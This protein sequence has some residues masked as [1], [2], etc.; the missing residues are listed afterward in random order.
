MNLSV[1]NKLIL[2][3][4]FSISGLLILLIFLKFSFNSIENLAKAQKTVETLSSDMLMLRRNEKD[5]IMRKDLKYKDKFSKNQKKLHANLYELEKLL[6]ASGVDSSDIKKFDT[7]ISQYKNIFFQ[8]IKKQQEIGLHHKDGLYG[9]L[10]ASVHKV[11]NSAK[12]SKNNKLLAIIYDLRKQEKD[13][14]LRRDMKYVDK[15]IK[16]HSSLLQ[17]DSLIKGDRKN[18]LILYKKDFLALIKAEQEIGLNSKV[19][20]QGKMR[21]VI[22]KSETLLKKLHKDLTIAIDSKK[23]KI[24]FQSIIMFIFIAG[25]II[26]SSAYIIRNISKSLSEFQSG[27]LGFFKYLNKQSDS[28]DMLKDKANDE[29]GNMAKIINENIIKTKKTIQNDDEFI[30]EVTLMVEDVNKGHL[31]KRFENKVESESLEKLRLSFNHMLEN[32]NNIIGGSTNKIIN[33]LESYEKLDFTNSIKDTKNKIPSTL[34][35]VSN[36]ITEMLIENKSTGLTLQQ[37]SQILIKNVNLL[38]TNSNKAATALEET[39]A[40][41]EQI[42]SNISNNTKNVVEMANH[43]QEVTQSVKTGQ[44]LANQTTNAMEE[45]NE[46]VTAI[47]EAITVIDQIAFQTN[48]LSL[49]AAVEAATA[50]EA[51][52][53]FAVVAGEVRNLASRS[54]EAANEIKSLV[55]KATQKAD[56]GK[57]I[58]D[59]MI[60][61]YSHLNESVSK[62]MDLISSVESGSKEQLLG[63]EQI[64]NAISSLDKQT[65]ENANIANQTNEI[66][67]QTDEIAQLIVKNANEKEFTG[68]DNV[69]AKVLNSFMDNTPKHNKKQITPIKRDTNNKQT[70]QA[71]LSPVVSNDS[72]DEWS[73]F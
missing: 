16:K 66:A 63:I 6:N 44:N 67:L 60:E 10:R 64:N 57:K 27:F 45:I 34:N 9:S 8:F 13:F 32:L 62:T 59:N 55:E 50:G 68:K 11:Q 22:H 7:I 54:A 24:L 52:K 33:V 42:T 26:L 72:D 47:H 19:G 4:I 3:T 40:A 39:A 25:I 2:S 38:N 21:K 43:S 31:F 61:G 48:I 23:E 49:N 5:F 20:L 1:K 69:Q 14:M 36:L 41:L 73:S 29:I 65:Q 18:N 15:F 12:E 37:S 17:K 28:V 51:G 71:T 46:E 53:G 56:E 70:K 58:S 30:H 35:N